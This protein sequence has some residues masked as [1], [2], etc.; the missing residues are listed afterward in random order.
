MLSL[1][2]WGFIKKDITTINKTTN[3]RDLNED[4]SVKNH[5]LLNGVLYEMMNIHSNMLDFLQRRQD[6]LCT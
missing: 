4:I 5:V 1:K 6:D 2:R 3:I